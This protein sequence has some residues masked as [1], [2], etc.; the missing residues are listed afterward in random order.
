[1][2]LASWNSVIWPIV[3][4]L[5]ALYI[6]GAIGVR[7]LTVRGPERHGDCA[8]PVLR[9]LAWAPLLS[10][11][12]AAAS[13]TAV[14]PLHI[15]WNW[16]TYLVCYA[17]VLVVIA[18]IRMA[19]LAH[20][21]RKNPHIP[22]HKRTYALTYL[23]EKVRNRRGTPAAPEPHGAFA[24]VL[25]SV[26]GVLTAAVLIVARL[27]R[28][29]PSPD[30]ITQNYDTV[31]HTNVVANIV[32]N[33]QA[34]SLHALSP[35][36]ETY[37]IAFQQFAALGNLA[38]PSIT[39]PAA[40]M[41]CW[42]AF[43]AIVYPISMLYLVR[44]ICGRHMLTD[45]AA[46]ALAAVAGGMPYLLLDWGTLY[47]MGTGQMLMPVLFAAAWRWFTVTWNRGARACWAGIGWMLLGTAAV[48]FAHFRVMMTFL[49]LVIPVFL[50]WCVQFGKYIRHRYGKRALR[51]TLSC[52]VLAIVLVF[53]AG[54]AVFARMYLVNNTR[55]I[56]SHLNGGQAQVTDTWGSAIMRF[57]TGTPINSLGQHMPVDWI[58]A[59]LLAIAIVSIVALR[60]PWRRWGLLFLGS[61]VLLGIICVA[62]A[63]TMAD[64]AKIITALWYKDQRRPF[65]AWAMVAI[66]LVC[67]GL[68]AFTDWWDTRMRTRKSVVRAIPRTLF[69]VLTVLCVLVSPQAN[70]MAASVGTTMQFAQ[71]G[72]DAPM[73][74][75]DEYLLL[76]RLAK[77]VPAQ[78]TI[79][80]DP[81]NGSGF[82]LAVGDRSLF[83]PHLAMVWDEDHAYL[84]SH[85]DQIETDPRVCQILDQYHLRWYLDMGGSFM[86]SPQHAVF[87]GM[88]NVPHSALK[89]V[90]SQGRA[91]L[92]EITA[93]PVH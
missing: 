24:R 83:Y 54:L 27:V 51:I 56:S 1:M 61:Y 10:V 91:A 20:E 15:R 6:P 62:S 65:S 73:L 93:C 59:V 80:A 70:A 63:A 89:L 90:D 88:D 86:P 46:P 17:I 32:I 85:L 87:E 29:V 38:A 72:Q 35:V 53:L 71:D 79:V 34:S 68:I 78:D 28:H 67:I 74:T 75:Q 21:R 57:L 36:R 19:V 30:Q 50:Y 4:I 76:K 48:S 26:F 9:T 31:F 3:A 92:Y 22:R 60:T 12:V 8:Y 66:P 7:M 82:A 14:Y 55:P 44:V 58:L 16:A 5:G 25:P 42:I 13:G 37:P 2:Q 47:S 11:V 64:W 84:A 41:A 52:V 23:R 39:V 18:A 40:T 33:G 81:W 45:F 77:D 49:L 69:C 43:A